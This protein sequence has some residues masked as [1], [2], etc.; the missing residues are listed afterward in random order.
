MDAYILIID[1]DITVST[2]MRRGLTYEGYEVVVAADGRAGL[3]KVL[4]RQPDLIILDVM[5]PGIDG[6]EVCRRLR[7]ETEVPVFMVT[8]RDSI[9]DRVMGL[10]TGA[11]DYLVKPFDFQ[12]LAARVK[13]LLRR[14]NKNTIKNQLTFED[15][16][17]HL[18]IRTSKRGRRTIEL[19]TTEFNLL[20]FFLQNPMIVLTRDI[21]MERVWGYDFQGESNVLEVYIGYL[22]QKMEKLGEPRLIHTVR[23]VGYALRL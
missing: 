22:R 6:L 18:G 8:A 9:A 13:A 5:M 20:L 23:G 10:E 16:T 19:S 15:L 11:D 17:L 7:K 3:L 21:I 1:D 12:E 14:S 4:D 2:M